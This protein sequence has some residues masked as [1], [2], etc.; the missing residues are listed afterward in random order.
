MRKAVEKPD[1]S[2]R[3]YWMASSLY[4]YTDATAKPYIYLI[5]G[6]ISDNLGVGVS[7]KLW[8]VRVG[9]VVPWHSRG[10]QT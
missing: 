1:L 8:L 2:S 9:S 6:G 4:L 10:C 7:L 5:D 3:A